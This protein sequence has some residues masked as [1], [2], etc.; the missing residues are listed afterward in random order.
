MSKSI[1]F[2]QT[3]DDTL[4]D[5]Y[6]VGLV[7]GMNLNIG[8][9]LT[10]YALYKVLSDMKLRV[11][12]IGNTI[13]KALYNGKDER[14][15]RFLELPY[16]KYDIAPICFNK[17]EL[18]KLNEVCD[19]FV[20]GSDQL[21]RAVF[22]E[23]TKYFTCLDWVC[24]SR[25][26]VSYGTSFGCAEF[27]GTRIMQNKMSYLFS[28][29][30]HLSV[31]EKNSVKLLEDSFGCEAE[32]VLDPV[33]LCNKKYYLDMAS[34]G[35]HRLPVGKFIGAYLLDVNDTKKGVLHYASEMLSKG[36]HQVITDYPENYFENDINILHEPSIEEW[37]AMID[38][39]DFFITDSFHGVCFAIIFKKQF[40]VC[41][42][43][44]NWRGYTRLQDILERLS[45][46]DRFLAEFSKDA[47]YEICQKHID[48]EQVNFWLNGEREKSEK[49]LSDVIA[50]RCDFSG[51]YNA[52][53]VFLEQKQEQ[54]Q[55]ELEWE[56][57][58]QNDIN[59]DFRKIRSGLFILEHA[60]L[61]GVHK[62]SEMRRQMQVIGFGA[63][64]CFR[65]NQEIIAKLYDLK[66]VC[67]NSPEKWGRELGNGIICISPKQLSG[68]PDVLVVIMVDSIKTAFDITKELQD[69]GIYNY[70]HITNWIAAI[71]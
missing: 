40:C 44:Q 43:K 35:K 31:R 42:D 33:F 11:L 6:D 34:I 47:V 67:D 62:P 39:C 69:M 59:G 61:H 16:K 60:T 26:K 50:G 71:S 29:F 52:H 14:F 1:F 25:Y 65:R 20:V 51:T 54:R 19:M 21:F 46:Q 32:C 63:G 4:Y 68:M 53:D 23:E 56:H 49:W 7:C 57:Y 22:V 66:Y 37:L 70:T 17:T 28:R 12:V 55:K 64:E 9:N 3:V 2:N 36:V 24:G 13:D 58:V 8:N 5:W 15:R 30:Q 38:S 41:F 45:L 18:Y 27:E 10:N 48:Y